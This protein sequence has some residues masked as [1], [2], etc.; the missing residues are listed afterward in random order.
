MIYFRLFWSIIFYLIEF[1]FPFLFFTFFLISKENLF[2]RCRIEIC[3]TDYGQRTPLE[4]KM[5]PRRKSVKVARKSLI[6]NYEK[7]NSYLRGLSDYQT[8][9]RRRETLRNARSLAVSTSLIKN[10]FCVTDAPVAVS[11]IFSFVILF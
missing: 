10:A 2:Y 6:N 7:D 4:L 9:V 1:A 8:K 11:R 5:A 3:I